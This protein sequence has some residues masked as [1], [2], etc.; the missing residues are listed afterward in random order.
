ME[1]FEIQIIE[2]VEAKVSYCTINIRRF[3]AVICAN[4]S[5]RATHCLANEH[6]LTNST[7]CQ[8][9]FVCRYD[10]CRKSLSLFVKRP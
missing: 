1:A 10:R 6:F 9:D 3:R 2:T 8:G 4:S 7:L 5:F